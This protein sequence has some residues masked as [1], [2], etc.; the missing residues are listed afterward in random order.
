MNASSA[1]AVTVGSSSRSKLSVRAVA[2]PLV[3]PDESIPVPPVTVPTC[4]PVVS[5]P[6]ATLSAAI[7]VFRVIL[8]EPSKLTP[9]AVTSP[10]KA[11]DL[12]VAKAVAVDALPV[13]APA[14]PT[15][16]NN[17][18]EGLYV[19]PVSVSNSLRSCCSVYKT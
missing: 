5:V 4:S 16:V 19:R 17:P 12:A 1:I 9:V 6:R 2:S 18:V 8:P 10:A 7:D 13:K 15:D 11:I 3:A 14:K